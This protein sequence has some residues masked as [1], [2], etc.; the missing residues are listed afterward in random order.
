M[1]RK[2]KLRTLKS[3]RKKRPETV[4]IVMERMVMM[5]MTKERRIKKL[6][7]RKKLLRWEIFMDFLESKF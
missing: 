7:L 1:E 2:L 3:L 5:L 4:L 6:G